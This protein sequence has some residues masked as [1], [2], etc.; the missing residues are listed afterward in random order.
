MSSETA[1]DRVI[2]DG[3]EVPALI[4]PDTIDDARRALLHARD[5][6][7][8]VVITGGRTRL[9][10][11]NVGGPFDIALSTRR[12]NRVV[13]YEPGDMT[14]A[15]EP[16]CTLRQIYTLLDEHN[17]A[18]ALDVAHDDVATIGGSYATGLSGPRRL[19][20]GSLK[21]WV[22]GVEVCGPDGTLSK[23]GGM[24]V[25]NVT[26]F[27]MMHVHF[28]ALGAFGLVTRLNLKVFPRTASSR[29]LRLTFDSAP[30]AYSS[31]ID[32]LRS[33]LQPGSVTVSND[34]GWVVD[35]RCDAPT[36]AIDRLVDRMLEV[37][38]AHQKPRTV[39]V[40]DD[41][42]EALQSFRTAV[43]LVHQ[44]G[45]V[46]LP[47]PASK[48]LPILSSLEH[49]GNQ[50]ICADLGS[51]LIYVATDPTT[52]WLATMTQMQVSPTYLSLPQALK[53]D[54]DVFGS[55]EAPAATVIRRM[56][57]AFDPDGTLN[58]GRFIFG[59]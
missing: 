47:V 25:K 16:G 17:Q 41:G 21:D 55:V 5:A 23:A 12:L 29:S 24:V 22:I 50:R 43:D 32:L 56:K 33:Q 40:L 13:S 51:G 27:D 19:S 42:N 14:L 39:D 53:Q 34:D 8:N 4:E 36:S 54:I 9:S 10:F 31:G 58:R 49:V 38:S 48:Q 35:V 3:V 52:E 45:V 28:G 59:L 30:D 2:I 18:I 37:A 44:S 26:G 1:V 46:R 7:Q 11:G 15:V 6:D 57:A 20:G